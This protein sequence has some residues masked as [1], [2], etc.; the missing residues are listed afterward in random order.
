MRYA[1]EPV[2][3][4]VDPELSEFLVRQLILISQASDSQFVMPLVYRD[5]DGKLP[6][7]MAEGAIIYVYEEGF[8]G[9]QKLKDGEKEWKKLVTQ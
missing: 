6:D 2:P 9:C 1:P 7:R 4:G 8:Y 5:S 3:L